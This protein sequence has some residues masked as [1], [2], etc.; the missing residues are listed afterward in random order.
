ML[1]D[2]K[3]FVRVAVQEGVD[4]GIVPVYHFGNSRVRPRLYPNATSPP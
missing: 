1:R 3:G 2:R 4:G